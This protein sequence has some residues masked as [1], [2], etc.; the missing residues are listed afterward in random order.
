MLLFFP[1]LLK[2]FTELIKIISLFMFGKIMHFNLCLELDDFGL[3]LDVEVLH[4]K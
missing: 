2:S 1:E 4:F 3:G